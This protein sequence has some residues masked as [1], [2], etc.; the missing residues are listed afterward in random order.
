MTVQFNSGFFASASRFWFGFCTPFPG[1][2][3]WVIIFQNKN[4]ELFNVRFWLTSK[5]DSSLCAILSCLAKML[6]FNLPWEFPNKAINHMQHT[7]LVQLLSTKIVHFYDKSMKLCQITNIPKTDI[8]GYG[9]KPNS[10]L[11][12]STAQDSKWPTWKRGW[13]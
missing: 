2:P 8:S 10:P 3:H 12:S 13:Q 9:A 1:C 4:P 5:D 7:L 6:S 11:D